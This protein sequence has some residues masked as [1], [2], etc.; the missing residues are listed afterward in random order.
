MGIKKI[1]SLTALVAGVYLIGRGA[2]PDL[3]QV[4]NYMNSNPQ[5]Q[6]L[7]INR[8]MYSREKRNLD[9]S[10][11]TLGNFSRAL[12]CEFSKD[13]YKKENL[14]SIKP[15]EKNEISQIKNYFYDL[16]INDILDIGSGSVK[17]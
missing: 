8:T 7:V 1:F 6:E 13:K 5:H 2:D 4:L 9:Y 15:K 12:M 11:E 14:H 17:E 3:G 10:S 16:V